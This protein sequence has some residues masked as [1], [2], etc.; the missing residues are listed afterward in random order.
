[1]FLCS[2][3]AHAQGYGVTQLSAAVEIARYGGLVDPANVRTVQ[4]ILR[5]HG[6]YS[7]RIDGI[8][9]PLTIAGLQRA[10]GMAGFQIVPVIR[11][12]VRYVV[13]EPMPVRVAVIP[14]QHHIHVPHLVGPALP[15]YGYPVQ[16]PAPHWPGAPIFVNY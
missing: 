13:P 9:G 6:L 15:S 7:G 14:P 3:V 12:N 16:L 1:M 4:S 2:P 8:A 5:A 10:Q 11:M